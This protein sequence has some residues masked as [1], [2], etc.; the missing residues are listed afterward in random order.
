[1]TEDGIP[2]FFP[3]TIHTAAIPRSYCFGFDETVDS[4]VKCTCAVFK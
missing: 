1:M 4:C 2:T 3:I